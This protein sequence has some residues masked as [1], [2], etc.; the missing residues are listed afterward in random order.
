[1]LNKINE[2]L[3]RERRLSTL[4]A[5]ARELAH[6]RDALARALS[7]SCYIDAEGRILSGLIGDTALILTGED[8]AYVRA[9][10]HEMED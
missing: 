8:D 5:V 1:M 3:D 10:I 6:E 9:A 7:Q 4:T 2:W